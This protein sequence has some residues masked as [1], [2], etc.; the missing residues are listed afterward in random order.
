MISWV[1]YSRECLKSG[2]IPEDASKAC[3]VYRVKLTKHSGYHH[4]WLAEGGSSIQRLW[5]VGRTGPFFGNR[6]A[7]PTMHWGLLFRAGV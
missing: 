4:P 6:T 3:A 7:F 2:S 1:V 5:K